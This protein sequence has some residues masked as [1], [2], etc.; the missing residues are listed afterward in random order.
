MLPFSPSAF[1]PGR[2]LSSEAD[3]PTDQDALCRQTL[4]KSLV[5]FGPRPVEIRRPRISQFPH[6]M[7]HK[8][9]LGGD[10]EDQ[11]SGDGDASDG[12]A[13]RRL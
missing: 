6:P 3:R 12:D 2:R 9:R 4:A 11:R 13:G 10:P 7:L 5:S 8:A 1:R